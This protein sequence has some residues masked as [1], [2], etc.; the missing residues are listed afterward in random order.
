[1]VA[2]ERAL[3]AERLAR[4]DLEKDIQPREF[5]V[6]TPVGGKSNIE[7][8]KPF[9]GVK[10]VFDFLPER[11]VR[12]SAGQ[13]A[14]AL[15]M[16]GWVIGDGT[17]REDLKDGVF[18]FPYSYP[19]G[20]DD[21]AFLDSGKCRRAAMELVKLLNAK[22]WDADTVIDPLAGV[23][24]NTIKISIGAKPA[25]HFMPPQWR[26]VE[27]R[28]RKMLEERR[29]KEEE[30]QRRYEEILRAHPT[31]PAATEPPKKPE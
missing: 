24:P 31:P 22:G 4:L 27:E 3:E 11:D 26:E 2:A 6:E 21:E 28:Q 1:L 15:Q 8:L 18:V 12:K 7:S 23:P 5:W 13:L 16:A 19:G 29:L 17:P 20:T 9:A 10:A 30:N 14:G 25:K